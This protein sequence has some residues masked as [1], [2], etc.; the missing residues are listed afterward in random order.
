MKLWIDD[1]R[2]APEGYIWCK[3]V[4][5]T[6][7]VIRANELIHEVIEVLDMD[8][9]AGDYAF[10]GGDYIK[11]LDWMEFTNR[12]YPIR[13]HSMNPVGRQNMLAICERNG[14]KVMY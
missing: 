5:Q 4:N 14:W 7:Q 1:E 3:S 9:D 13:V 11:I 6:K 12:S 8:H 2:P 10:D